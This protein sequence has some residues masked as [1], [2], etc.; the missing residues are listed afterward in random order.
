[1]PARTLV[2]TNDFPPRTG[3]IESFVLAMTTRMPADSV[4][5]LTARQP[6]DAA[7]DASL[8][9]PVVRDRLPVLVPTP[10]LARRAAA[11]AARFGCD[12]VWFGAA[13]PLGLLAP[14]LRSAGIRR[15]V[16]TTH[17]H[18]VWWARS[19]ISRSLLHRIGET[20]DVLTYLGEFT[21]RRISAALSPAAAAR[22]V[23]LTPGV[24]DEAFAPGCGG[25]AVRASL[26]LGDRPVV[27]CVSRIVARK[28]QDMLVR[29][30]PLIRRRVPDTALLLVGDGPHR[31][32]VESIV[33]SLGLRQ[34][35]VLTGAQP[36]S[37]LAP[38][39]D[40]GDVFAMPTRT[41]RAGFEVEGLG[42]VYLEA[43]AT[44]LPV[45]AGSSGGAP[46]AVLDGESG[47]VVNGRSVEAIAYRVSQL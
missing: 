44:G 23:R 29:A 1:M 39:F 38:Y 18:E 6:G 45:V 27:V 34:S 15:T 32:R 17:G 31:R 40:A 19:P 28:G 41:R 12:R 26:G 22:M 30:L 35:V 5:V 2:V 37:A 7:Y 10:G 47:F 46:D 4:V 3:G 13:A 8:P 43:A 9:F 33:D 21:R 11:V 14:A 24:D 25:A 36:W 42:I 16:A 20:N